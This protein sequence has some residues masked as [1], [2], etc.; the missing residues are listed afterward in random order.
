MPS[1]PKHKRRRSYWKY[2]H[3]A[4]TLE[5][6]AIVRYI[7]ALVKENPPP[8]PKK[9]NRGRKPIHSWEKMVCICILMVVFNLTYRQMQSIIP[10]LRLPWNDDEP[11]PD[12]TWIAKTFKRIPLQYLENILHK[13]AIMCIKESGWSIIIIIKKRMIAVDSTGVETDRYDKKKIRPIKHKKRFDKVR[14]KRF[15]K[16]HVI[17]ILD[18]LIILTARITSSNTHDSPVLRSMLSKVKSI[19]DLNG[20]TMNAD[21]AYDG[22]ANYKLL[23][24]LNIRPNIKQK[25][26]NNSKRYKKRVKEFD[27]DIY[28]YRGLIEG[29]FGAEERANHKNCRYFIKQNQMRF[30]IIK[31]IGWNIQVLNRIQCAKMLAVKITPL[32]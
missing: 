21:S 14:S 1:M 19:Y 23:Y 9:S 16:W 22:E 8:Y 32:L 12:H 10:S 5:N 29:I 15:L 30:G 27:E 11:Y 2:Y 20:S 28:R 3:L 13:V 25:K 18:P 24:S 4:H 7:V 31:A 26:Y 17:A 6:D